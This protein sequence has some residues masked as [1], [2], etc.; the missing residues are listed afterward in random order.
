MFLPPAT[1]SLGTVD[2]TLPFAV[3]FVFIVVEAAVIPFSNAA[4]LT[5][6]CITGVSVVAFRGIFVVSAV[7]LFGSIT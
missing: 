3:V 7:F 1:T 6:D 2:I 4:L 5:I